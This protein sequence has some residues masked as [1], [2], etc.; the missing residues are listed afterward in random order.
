MVAVN[1]ASDGAVFGCGDRE[2]PPEGIALRDYPLAEV[3]PDGDDAAD[4]GEKD[5]VSL[6][7]LCG[8]SGGAKG[9]S[10]GRAN[11][12]NHTQGSCPVAA[13]GVPWIADI[14]ESEQGSFLEKDCGGV[15]LC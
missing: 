7:P 14:E 2:G 4:P 1:E 15:V 10:E 12:E 3:A 8:K 9:D 13:E 11:K 6:F 5:E